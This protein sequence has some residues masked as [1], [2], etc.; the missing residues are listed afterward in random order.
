MVFFCLRLSTRT[1]FLRKNRPRRARRGPHD[2]SG[3]PGFMPPT[4]E[5]ALRAWNE[6]I[7]P[8]IHDEKLG[9]HQVHSTARLDTA[10]KVKKVVS[11][12]EKP[13]TTAVLLSPESLSQPMTRCHPPLGLKRRPEP[14]QDPYVRKNDPKMT[15]N[16]PR[17]DPKMTLR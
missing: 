2:L 10:K 16:D 1:N 15:Q 3:R 17:N 13:P 9:S 8:L 6:A 7:T 4:Q 12:L 11:V 5:S 14:P